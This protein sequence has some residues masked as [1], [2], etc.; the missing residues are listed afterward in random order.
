MFAALDRNRGVAVTEGEEVVSNSR[1][2][3]ETPVYECLNCGETLKYTE[4]TVRCQQF[5]HH[6]SASDCFNTGNVSLS[7][8]LCQEAVAVRLVNRLPAPAHI[9]DV[10]FERWVTTGR[11]FLI[12]DV[13]LTAPGRLAIEVVNKNRQILERRL[14]RLLTA[15]YGVMVV[16]VTTGPTTAN[17]LERRLSSITPVTVGRFDPGT[18]Q[19]ALGSI[20]TPGDL[21][22]DTTNDDRIG[23]SIDTDTRRGQTST[24][25]RHGTFG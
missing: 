23:E 14:H 18:E 10:A 24:R 15:G 17:Q 19:L 11:S 2:T 7:H 3:S 5:Q 25:I 12:P 21:A 22:E 6:G 9:C 13:Q 16:N 20:V 8:R 1:R 4:Q